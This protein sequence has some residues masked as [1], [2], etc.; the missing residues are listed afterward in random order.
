MQHITVLVVASVAAG[1]GV[2][3][4][5]A[6]RDAMMAVPGLKDRVTAVRVKIGDKKME[7]VAIPKE[8]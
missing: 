4:P 5:Q 1:G 2:K 6:T 7:A 8:T 3:N